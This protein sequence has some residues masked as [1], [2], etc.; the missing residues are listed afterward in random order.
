[1]PFGRQRARRSE[2]LRWRLEAAVAVS[3][4]HVRR[5]TRLGPGVGER[6]HMV[7]IQRCTSHGQ[8][9]FIRHGRSFTLFESPCVGVCV[10]CVLCCGRHT[11]TSFGKIVRFR[12]AR[13]NT[14]AQFPDSG[15]KKTGAPARGTPASRAF[16]GFASFCHLWMWL[17]IERCCVVCATHYTAARTNH[18]NTG[19]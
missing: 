16:R 17:F 14:H 8:S 6:S 4:R 1:M 18:N 13:E 15:A 19:A 9:C 11:G 7:G 12:R 2:A 5:L 10:Y 3:S